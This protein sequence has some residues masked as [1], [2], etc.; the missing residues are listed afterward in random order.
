MISFNTITEEGKEG[1]K[2]FVLTL[3]LLATKFILDFL[4]TDLKRCRVCCWLKK[5]VMQ[6]ISNH[7]HVSGWR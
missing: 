1:F 7:G 6:A 5:T 4:L 2:D 3:P